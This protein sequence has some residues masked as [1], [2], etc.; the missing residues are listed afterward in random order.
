LRHAADQA[1]RLANERKQLRRALRQAERERDA[2]RAKLAAAG[3][4][5]RPAASVTDRFQR[6]KRAFALRFHP[7]RVAGGAAERHI[8]AA[9]FQEF[10]AE[11]R[12]IERG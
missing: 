6:A 5:T 4:A 11:L 7:D 3:P 10:W 1:E 12:R 8:R 2:L 9:I